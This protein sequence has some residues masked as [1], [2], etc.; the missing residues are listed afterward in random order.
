MSEASDV[1]KVA[2]LLGTYIANQGW[3]SVADILQW[4]QTEG[5]DHLLVHKALRFLDRQKAITQRLGPSGEAGW[6]S[7]YGRG[8]K[9]YGALSQPLALRMVFVTEP[10]GHL[11]DD[12]DIRRF[13]RTLDGQIIFTPAQWR[14]GAKKAYRLAGL[15]AYGDTSEAAVDRIYVRFVGANPVN[16]ELPVK[17]RRPLSHARAPV[18]VIRHECLPPG[19]WA[20]WLIAYP[21][22]HFTPETFAALL[23]AYEDVGFSPAGN[24]RAGGNA[25]LFRWERRPMI[26]AQALASAPAEHDTLEVQYV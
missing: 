11:G 5:I 3:A 17:I 14:A 25:G 26:D 13:Q 8:T 19:S 7:L 12:A 24:G 2:Q 21:T 18:G 6:E 22:S 20:D 4:A 23:R 10:L 1:K 16:G 9:R 15:G